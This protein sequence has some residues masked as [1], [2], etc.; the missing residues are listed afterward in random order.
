MNL[1]DFFKRKQAKQDRKARWA[2][3]I[4]SRLNKANTPDEKLEIITELEFSLEV[5]LYEF[6]LRNVK[7]GKKTEVYQGMVDHTIDLLKSNSETLMK[8]K[9]F[10]EKLMEKDKRFEMGYIR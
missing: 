5:A 8:Q 1:L 3:A 4:I 9:P 2:E 10:D 6:T 7:K